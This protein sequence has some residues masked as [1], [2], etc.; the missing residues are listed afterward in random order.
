MSLKQYIILLIMCL[1]LF[2]CGQEDPHDHSHAAPTASKQETEEASLTQIQMQKIGLELGHFEQKPLN[3]TIKASGILEIPPQNKA[4]VS[5]L[6][7]GRILNIHVR[8]GQSIAKGGL[9]ATLQN[10]TLVEWQEKLMETEG[11]L[12]YLTKEYERQLNLVAKDVAPQKQLEKVES[13]LKVAQAHRKA[14]RAKLRLVGISPERLEDQIVSSVGIRSPIGGFVK[15]IKVN[16]GSFVEKNQELFEVV[17]NHHIHIDLKVFEKDLPYLKIGQEIDF[18]LQSNPGKVMRASIFAIGKAMD[19]QD[20][21][22]TVHAEI[23]NKSNQLL[24]GMYVEARIITQDKKVRALP[25]SA[26]VVDKGLEYIFVKEEEH[27]NEVHFQKIQVITGTRDIGF[28]EIDPLQLVTNE[29][30]IVV[31]GAFYLM[32]QTKKGEEGGGHHH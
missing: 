5:T 3:A 9:L 28:V 18:S 25:E 20:R 6:L 8:P 21:T 30:E 17:D 26:V 2:G 29:D 4:S 10:T 24:P 12:L 11:Q 7:E 13:D 16:T 31:K 32:A 22:V 23:D 1:A 19:E 15:N 14:L 27:E